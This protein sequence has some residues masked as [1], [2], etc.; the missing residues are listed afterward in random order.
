ML[1]YAVVDDG[2][3][4]PAFPLGDSLEVFVSR[5]DAEEFIEE[6]RGDDPEV[7]A[8]RSTNRA[9]TAAPAPT[10]IKSAPTA[11]AAYTSP[12]P[13]LFPSRKRSSTIAASCPV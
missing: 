1:V 11:K 4:T 13:L 6:V 10:A 5:E 2:L 9:A 7:A 8:S 12:Q 3:S